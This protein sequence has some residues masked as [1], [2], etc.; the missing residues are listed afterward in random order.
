MTW[1]Y[2]E[3]D[4]GVRHWERELRK[5]LA[6]YRRWQPSPIGHVARAARNWVRHCIKQIRQWEGQR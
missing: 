3:I 6:T 5:A 1:T 2:I 4:N